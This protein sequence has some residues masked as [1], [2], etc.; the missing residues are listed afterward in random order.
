MSNPGSYSYKGLVRQVVWLLS[1][2]VFFNFN[3]LHFSFLCQ[4]HTNWRGLILHIFIKSML[5]GKKEKYFTVWVLIDDE[6]VRIAPNSLFQLSLSINLSKN[7]FF[8]WCLQLKMISLK[9]LIVFFS[10]L[11][12]EKTWIS[13]SLF[14]LLKQNDSIPLDNHIKWSNW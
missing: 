10:L 11:P 3:G 1:L 8:N 9:D 13:I 6:I 5:I 4:Y 7:F 14:I 12:K 2:L